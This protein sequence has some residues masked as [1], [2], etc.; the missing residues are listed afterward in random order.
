M[1]LTI[2]TGNLTRDPES[3]VGQNGK[4]RTVFSIA[5]NRKYVSQDG[6]RKADF[7]TFTCY[8]RLAENVAKYLAKGR[9]CTVT[10]HVQSGSYTNDEGKTVYTTQFIAD[11]VEFLSSKQET[12]EEH[13]EEPAPA[14]AQN[15][16]VHG[17]PPVYPGGGFTQ[18]DEEELPF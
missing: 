7:L 10:G 1:N 18:V 6:S 5:V 2:H 17:G 3:K 8:D 4:M 13:A 9:K 16:H 11:D 15:Q 14:P 12:T